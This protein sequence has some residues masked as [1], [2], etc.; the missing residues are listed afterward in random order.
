MSVGISPVW[1]SAEYSIRFNV[2]FPLP[3]LPSASTVTAPSTRSSHSPRARSTTSSSPTPA[4]SSAATCRH[5]RSADTYETPT[6]AS[7]TASPVAL[8]PAAPRVQLNSAP[9]PSPPPADAHTSAYGRG[10]GRSSHSG[11]R[12]GLYGQESVA[13]P[14]TPSSPG[15]LA[16]A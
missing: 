10:T 1:Y 15:P 11:G 6:R 4:G 8:A 3:T 14:S 7:T 13:A 9:S 12:A 5:A 2:A 16:G